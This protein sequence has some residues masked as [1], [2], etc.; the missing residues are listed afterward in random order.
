[1]FRRDARGRALPPPNG[2]GGWRTV[3][4]LEQVVRS[5]SSWRWP[6]PAAV[7]AMR[8]RTSSERKRTPRPRR[9]RR[10]LPTA[11]RCR[12]APLPET[13][14]RR[15]PA[16]APTGLPL[17]AATPTPP[18]A[19][20]SARSP[21]A[22][23]VGSLRPARDR[24]SPLRGGTGPPTATRRRPPI[25]GSRHGPTWATTPRRMPPASPTSTPASPRRCTRA[26]TARRSTPRCSGCRRWASTRSPFN[27]SATF[28]IPVRR[29][30]WSRATSA[31]RR[32]RAAA[33]FTS[34]TT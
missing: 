31:T 10:M 33:S 7:R 2:V 3:S 8:R 27:A 28:A 22:I 24:A 26:A 18:R 30:T 1:M 20:S 4:S 11:M 6:S 34:C 14:G 5:R 16:T 21:S 19:I 32:R 15:D 13:P 9:T 17:T 25:S 23:R 29:G 12:T